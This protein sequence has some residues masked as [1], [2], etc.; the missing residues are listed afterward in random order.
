MLKPKITCNVLKISDGKAGHITVSD[1]VIEAIKKSHQVKIIDLNI[2]IRA[3]F[4]IRILRF[5][6]KY[7]LL[8][9]QWVSSTL[10]M[11][12]FYQ[13][14]HKPDAK[15][16][17]VVSTG[18]DTQF[19]NI[20]LSRVLNTKNIFCGT[21]KGV[22]SNY[23]SFIVSTSELA[24]SN[25]IKLDILPTRGQVKNIDQKVQQF[26]QEKHL[27]KNEKYFVLLI[28]G[29]GSGYTYTEDEYETLVHSFMMIVKKYGAKALITTSRRTG[30]KYETFLKSLL[31]HYDNDIAYSVY[32]GQAPEKV[33]SMYLELASAIFVTEESGS[34]IS[35]S[36]LSRKPIFTLYPKIIQSQ[37]QYRLFLERLLAKRRIYRLSI[38][39][40][41]AAM[42]YDTFVFDFLKK[43]P[44]DEL[45]EKMQPF[46][47]KI[48]NKI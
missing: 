2:K 34:M 24:V 25:S 33:V 42:E 43:L 22:D 48:E 15:I 37:V 8:S 30:I 35:E 31:S 28:G 6:L 7:N 27:E 1:G 26:C 44:I 20:W 29:D 47:E 3:K 40:G 18:G 9:Y 14:F 17:V 13:N 10:F 39:E 16:D 32:F 4:L 12:L 45:A 38:G 41:L 21:L 46:L 23:F 36:L 5:I 11:K 19:A